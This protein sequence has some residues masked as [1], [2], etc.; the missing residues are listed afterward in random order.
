HLGR[1]AAQSVLAVPLVAAQ[2][3]LGIDQL[4]AGQ[5]LLADRRQ[6]VEGDQRVILDVLLP[7]SVIVLRVAVGGQ[8]KLRDRQSL[9]TDNDLRVAS[10]APDEDHA[11]ALSRSRFRTGWRPLRCAASSPWS[12]RWGFLPQEAIDDPLRS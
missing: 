6:P 3:A 1:V 11:V 8:S 10:Q 9:R 5:E 12:G 7:V 4:A 2:P